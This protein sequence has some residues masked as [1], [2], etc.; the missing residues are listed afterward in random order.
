MSSL[1]ID[2]I[3][4]TSN[5]ILVEIVS[6]VHEKLTSIVKFSPLRKRTTP[7]HLYYLF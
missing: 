6:N 5:M 4:I 2:S 3:Q 7:R 1:L